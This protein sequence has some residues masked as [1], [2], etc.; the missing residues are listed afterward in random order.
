M[1]KQEITHTNPNSKK[2]SKKTNK[3]LCTTHL[4]TG[5]KMQNKKSKKSGITNLAISKSLRT[6][7]A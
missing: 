1:G 6:P 7:T 3:Q 5:C 4:Q 2:A